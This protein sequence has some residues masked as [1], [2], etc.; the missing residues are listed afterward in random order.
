LSPGDA[1]AA[2]E[3]APAKRLGI[4][5]AALRHRDFQLFAA[6]SFLSTNAA[7]MQAVALGWQVYDLTGSALNLGLIGLAEFLPS[8]L[9]ALLAGHVADRFDRRIVCFLCY[10]L[11]LVCAALL[12]L[13]AVVGVASIWPYLA[14]ALL[15]GIARAFVAP[16]SRAMPPTLVPDADF[17]NAIAW[18]SILWDAA[19][20]AGPVLGGY[21]YGWGPATVYGI[22]GAGFALSALLVA[23]IR[24]RPARLSAEPVSWGSVVAGVRLIR[25][26][27]VLLGAISLDL[28]AV[29]FGGATALLP[30]FAKDILQVGTEGLGHLRAAPAVGAVTMALLLAVWPIHRKV[31]RS[32]FACVAAFGVATVVFGLSTSFWLSLAALFVIGA[33]DMVSVFIRVAIVPAV[34]PDNLRGRVLAVEQIFIGASNELGAFE[35]GAVAA[36]IGAVSTVVLGG[37]ATI[38]VVALWLKLFPALRDVDRF[39]TA[40]S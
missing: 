36:L 17:P 28:F 10:L 25:R 4:G 8:L 12:V 33:A 14:V 7:L 6:V 13:F 19:V 38:L 5:I 11:E 26:T 18:G 27:P 39:P 31:G 29:L 37:L 40:P 3:A 35:S 24:P 9:L 22:A 16:A 30:V 15:F 20:I 34:T 2:A 32:L 23:A 1:S 21:C